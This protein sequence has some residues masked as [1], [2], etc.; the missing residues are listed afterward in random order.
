MEEHPSSVNHQQARY[1]PKAISEAQT[2]L[3]L[4]PNSLI[5]HA[6]LALGNISCADSRLGSEATDT[7]GYGGH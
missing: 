5:H 2:L 1:S 6:P 4:R 7:D 3:R